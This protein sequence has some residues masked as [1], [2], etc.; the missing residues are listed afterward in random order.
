MAKALRDQ[1]A[2]SVATGE[3]EAVQWCHRANVHSNASS[4]RETI[5]W[6]A[7]HNCVARSDK[8]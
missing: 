8:F 1:V 4:F 7:R 2:T 6:Y 3:E 5:G